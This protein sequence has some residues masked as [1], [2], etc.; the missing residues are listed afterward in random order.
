M[1]SM[2][3]NALDIVFLDKPTFYV[4]YRDT[5]CF[6][7]SSFQRC[8]LISLGLKFNN[9]LSILIMCGE[10]CLLFLRVLLQMFL[11][12]FDQ[13]LRNACLSDAKQCFS[14]PRKQQLILESIIYVANLCF[15]GSPEKI[16]F[17]Y[18]PS[19]AVDSASSHMSVTEVYQTAPFCSKSLLL[20]KNWAF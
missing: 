2:L 11:S 7:K 12:P 18:K 16:I 13:C 19:L 9:R 14:F 17:W 3:F 15:C 1:W 8:S 5:F 4:K 10:T 20:S 6:L